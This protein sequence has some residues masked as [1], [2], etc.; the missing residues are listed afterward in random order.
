MS[1]AVRWAAWACAGLSAHTLLNAAVL[2]RPA[3]AAG[4]PAEVAP[5]VSVLVPAR[6]EAHRIAPCI[7]SLLAQDVD[8]EILVLDD[9]STDGTADVVRAAAGGDPRLRVLD[10]RPLP[11]GWLG[12][13]H[14]CQQLADAARGDVLVFVDADVVVAPGGLAATLAV[15]DAAGLDLASPYPRQLAD[16]AGPRLL[17]PL[18]QWSWLTFL[19]LR[20]AE[21]GPGSMTAANGQ[22]LAVRAAA[23][24]AAGGH[25]AV[26]AEVIEDVALA[27]AVKAAGGSATVVD[28][29]AVA[30]CRMYADW[31]EVREG[32]AKSLWAAFGS[33]PGAAAAGALLSWLYLAPPAAGVYG[34]LRRRRDLALPG[35]GGYA[36]AVAGRAV[37]ARVTGARPADALA[38]PVGITALLWLLAVSWR[39]RIDGTLTWKG[40]AVGG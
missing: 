10:G 29:T 38:H 4:H 19:P 8:C 34:L 40:R 28:G 32:Y 37:A 1:R 26:R 6:D 16:S 15:L 23:Y 33:R 22:L 12:K 39:R 36:A 18:L 11:A 3:T 30:E 25:R 13:P 20:L 17:Q 5:A 27:R 14:A 24:R 2:R 21:R 35:L 31:A 9:G 7:R